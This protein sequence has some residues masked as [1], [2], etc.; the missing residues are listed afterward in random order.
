VLDSIP[1]VLSLWYSPTSHFFLR[2]CPFTPAADDT[3]SVPLRSEIVPVIPLLTLLDGTLLNAYLTLHYPDDILEKLLGAQPSFFNADEAMR[4]LEANG[5][6]HLFIAYAQSRKR[7]KQACKTWAV[8]GKSKWRARVCACTPAS[9]C[10]FRGETANPRPS[11]W[12]P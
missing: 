4:M 9:S 8:R 12:K 10:P 5:R 7:H 2:T 1:W 6:W 11:A 3:A